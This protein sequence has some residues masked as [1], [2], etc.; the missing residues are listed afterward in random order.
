MFIHWQRT[1]SMG[2]LAE[3]WARIFNLAADHNIL[4]Q[5]GFSTSLAESAWWKFYLHGT[6]E[7]SLKSPE[8]G[9]ELLERKGHAT[10]QVLSYLSLFHY[11]L[12]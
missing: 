6:S 3:I 9:I 7:W 2:L 1:M 4:F 10:K 12:Y 8:Q 11:F 5:P